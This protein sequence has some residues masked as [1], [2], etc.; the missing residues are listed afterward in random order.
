MHEPCPGTVSTSRR[1]SGSGRLS[2]A[3]LNNR[4]VFS[5]VMVLPL[6]CCLILV[7]RTSCAMDRGKILINWWHRAAELVNANATWVLA[8]AARATTFGPG[9][10]L[11]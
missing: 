6:C 10:S 11:V 3:Y 7:G 8:G 5:M 1:S 9:A 4:G 2:P